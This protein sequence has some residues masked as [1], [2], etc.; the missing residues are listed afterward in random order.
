[1]LSY[2]HIYHFGNLADVHKHYILSELLFK[3]KEKN[4]PISYIETHSGS[5]IYNKQSV[6]SLKT[7]EFSYGINLLESKIK[8]SNYIKIINNIR[9]IYGNKYY[10]GSPMI[11]QQIL[12]ITDSINLMELHPQEYLK[13]KDNMYK[14]KNT[15]IHKKDGYKGALAISP[16]IIKRGIILIDP[17]FEIKE[18]YEIIV[19]FIIKLHKKWST[20]VIMLWYPVLQNNLYI[21]MVK[22]IE[23]FNFPKYYKNEIIFNKNN[24]P[25]TFKLLGSGVIIINMPFELNKNLYP[26]KNIFL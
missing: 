8:D 15:H 19:D 5:G 4:K 16:T 13:L 1:M 20:A 12:S 21:N 17:S 24:L 26:L 6:E 2:Q 7:A 9:N 25:E 11:A 22:K 23:K 3:L 10:P 18:E 14:F